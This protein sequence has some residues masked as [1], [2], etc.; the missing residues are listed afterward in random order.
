MGIDFALLT[1]TLNLFL[2]FGLEVNLSVIRDR[3]KGQISLIEGFNHSELGGVI[4]TTLG[5]QQG[6]HY[7]LDILTAQGLTRD[8]DFILQ[9]FG[10]VDLHGVGSPMR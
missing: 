7:V 6:Q 2:M 8:S 1:S 3:L 9:D 4:A 10:D 5:H